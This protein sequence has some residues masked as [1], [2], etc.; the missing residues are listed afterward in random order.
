MSL[1]NDF[2]STYFLVDIE[3][4]GKS[5]K[6]KIDFEMNIEDFQ[7]LMCA[8]NELISVSLY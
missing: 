7:F 5:L 4:S 3:E 8:F 6:P 1:E 2:V